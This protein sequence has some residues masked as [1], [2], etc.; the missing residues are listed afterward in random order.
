MKYSNNPYRK[1]GDVIVVALEDFT[2]RRFAKLRANANDANSVKDMLNTLI[3]KCGL[4]LKVLNSAEYQSIKYSKFD[5][6]FHL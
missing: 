6:E 5:E 1:Q 4:P 3:D 2:G